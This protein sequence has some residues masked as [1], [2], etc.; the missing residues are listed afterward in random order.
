MWTGL[1]W[2]V[3][4][5]L[6]R[7]AWKGN[8]GGRTAQHV[9]GSDDSWTICRR[10]GAEWNST[11]ASASERADL[12]WRL[13]E[14]AVGHDRTARCQEPSITFAPKKPAQICKTFEFLTFSE[15][16][17]HGSTSLIPQFPPSSLPPAL[18]S[19]PLHP[20]NGLPFTTPTSAPFPGHIPVPLPTSI[21]FLPACPAAA[22]TL[23]RN[24]LP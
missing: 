7:N 23:P 24:R 8:D 21:S 13:H 17:H 20:R 22:S 9:K 2:L 1:V 18:F 4:C 10:C 12:Y 5:E 3:W 16:S 14:T 19:L 15:I 11:R 6:E